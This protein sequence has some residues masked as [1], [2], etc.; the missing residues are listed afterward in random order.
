[1]RKSLLF[2]N[3]FLVIGTAI[4]VITAAVSSAQI[5]TPGASG[6]PGFPGTPSITN[7]RTPASKPLAAVLAAFNCQTRGVATKVVLKSDRT[8]K[9]GDKPFP[10]VSGL[11]QKVG[12]AYRFKDGTLKNQSIV[13]LR[14][15]YY[16]VATAKEAR[17]ASIAAT[18]AALVCTKKR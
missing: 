13:Q 10:P 15:S 17:A 9:S 12:D 11:Y 14:N 7:P 4:P 3:F 5:A 18:D 8:Y 6:S 1:M 16:L 2:L